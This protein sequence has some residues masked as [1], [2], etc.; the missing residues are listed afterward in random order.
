MRARTTEVDVARRLSAAHH[1]DSS[2]ART[3]CRAGAGSRLSGCAHSPLPFNVHRHDAGYAPTKG[4]RVYLPF[5][6]TLR[7]IAVPANAMHRNDSR[8]A[9]EVRGIRTDA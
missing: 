7:F 1:P 3:R 8:L 6:M 9:V 4:F 5:D 2:I